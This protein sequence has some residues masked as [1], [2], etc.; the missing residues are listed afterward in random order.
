ME[1]S[2][3]FTNSLVEVKLVAP[4]SSAFLF[5]LLNCACHHIPAGHIRSD[6]IRPEMY[7]AKPARHNFQPRGRMGW[8]SINCYITDWHKPRSIPAP[9]T[10]H[11]TWNAPTTAQRT[12]SP[13][14][15]CPFRL[16]RRKTPSN[17]AKTGKI[18]PS[19]SHP[20]D[21]QPDRC[22][23]GQPEKASQYGLWRSGAHRRGVVTIIHAFLA[24][25]FPL[26]PRL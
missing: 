12:A 6:S 11:S 16:S 1:T 7:L 13:G 24:Q 9:V 23:I 14:P 3:I 21:F 20:S 26:C 18:L 4:A 17:H 10:M 22:R 2:A 5:Q 19:T 15:P 8:H 25:E